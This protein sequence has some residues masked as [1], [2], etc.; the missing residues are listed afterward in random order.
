MKPAQKN[1]ALIL[2]KMALLVAIEVVLGRFLSIRTPIVTIGFGFVPIML[3][4]MLFGPA[5]G[6]IVGGA[7]DFLGAILFPIGAYFPGFTLTGALTG[8]IYGICLHKRQ[9]KL[10]HAALAA[11]LVNVVCSL[12]LDTL[13]LYIIMNN[14]VLALLPTRLIKCAVMIPI[15]IL[16]IQ[17]VSQ[18]VDSRLPVQP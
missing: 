7:S 1:Q 17:A 18:Q 9:P 13:W 3:A 2:V 4:A 10:R 15:Q 12:C 5:R 14:G 11:L 16:V 6:A 8:A